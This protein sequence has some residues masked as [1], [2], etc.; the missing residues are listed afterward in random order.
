MSRTHSLSPARRL[1]CSL[2][3]S[4]FLLL[5]VGC[6]TG[7]GF[8]NSQ[9]AQAAYTG[10][11]GQGFFGMVVENPTVQPSVT[12]GARRLVDPSVSW[13]A[14]EPARGAFSWSALDAEVAASQ[15]QSVTLVL[16][17]TPKWASSNPTLASLWG[18]GA[19]AIPGALAD[20]DAY[21]TAVATRYAG[22]I[23]AYEVWNQPEDAT[24]WSGLASALGTDMATLTAHAAADIHAA[25][26]DA[27]CVS[28]AL[29]ATAMQAF[30]TAGGGASVDVLATSL[31]TPGASP[32]EMVSALQQVRA[33]AVAAGEAA[34]PIWNEQT[35]WTLPAG[36][37]DEPTQS[38]WVA[39][40]LLL[41]AG[42]GVAR[43]NWYAWG[44]TAA[45]SLQMTDSSGLAAM[46]AGAYAQVES[47]LKGAQVNGCSA[48]PSGLWTCGL[49]KNGQT[50]WVLWSTR[51][52]VQTSALGET[53][54][55]DIYGSEGAVQADGTVTV[56]G[57]PV[58]LE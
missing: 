46:P 1:A 8:G 16:G 52:T 15:G 49:T 25:D 56:T 31:D 22:R 9:A 36:G 53:E 38:A 7:S 42:Y 55:W 28:P 45:G 20:W 41:N 14:L 32:E 35:A 27:L 4:L 19:T 3:A 33:A 57:S 54:V 51:G 40:A 37:L 13:A 12:I 50:E 30:L 11:V 2:F 5:P 18:A 29:S 24:Q 23:T 58:L 34:K 21:V 39:R 44:A 47:W 10:T 26:K 17:M 48:S 6:A 43:M